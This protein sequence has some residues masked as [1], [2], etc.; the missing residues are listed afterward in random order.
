MSRSLKIV[1]AEDDPTM[2][3]FYRQVLP[4]L[5]HEV[6]TAQNGQQ[7]VEQCRL[8]GPDLVISGIRMADLDGIAA[9]AE[10]W[11][12][13]PL[14]IILV[15]AYHDPDL[16][17]RAEALPIFAYLLKPV[18]ADNLEAA[19][20]VAMRRFEE[21][22][23]LRREAAQLRRALEERKVLERAKGILMR[24]ARLDEGEAHRRLQHAARDHNMKL[25]EVAQVLL[26]LEGALRPAEE[27]QRSG[28]D[29][30]RQMADGA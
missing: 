8:L 23:A 15:S 2:G 10:V 27:V 6:C 24:C 29:R 21:A 7:L 1:V 14:P 12:E 18:R 22:E 16:I 3:E 28:A 20:A 9:A 5:G 30:V 13:R 4:G 25:V 26:V 17:R 11:R 19:I